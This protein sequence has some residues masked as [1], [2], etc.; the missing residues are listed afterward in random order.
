MADLAGHTQSGHTRQAPQQAGLAYTVGAHQL[1][2]FTACDAEVNTTKQPPVSPLNRNLSG[3]VAA[4]EVHNAD[5]G[6]TQTVIHFNLET[7]KIKK[8]LIE[9]MRGCDITQRSEDGLCSSRV[10]PLPIRSACP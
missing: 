10:L 7:L 3:F 2:D 6:Q 1:P 9:Q 5:I 8:V 4:S